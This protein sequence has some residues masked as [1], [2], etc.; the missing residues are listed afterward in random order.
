MLNVRSAYKSY[1][2][3]VSFECHRK[4]RNPIRYAM[5]HVVFILWDVSHAEFKFV[6]DGCGYVWK[7]QGD[8]E[9]NK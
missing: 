3:E 1:L 8:M 7:I 2:E 6:N 5:D 4:N 9:S